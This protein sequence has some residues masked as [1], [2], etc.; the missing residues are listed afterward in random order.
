[1]IWSSERVS[2][3][4]EVKGKVAAR[5]AEERRRGNKRTID[6]IDKGA[7]S[8]AP[9]IANELFISTS[10]KHW[11]YDEATGDGSAM[12]VKGRDRRG[13]SGSSYLQTG[14]QWQ[15]V[16]TDRWCQWQFV[17]TDRGCQWQFVFTDRGCQWQLTVHIYRQVV[18]V[19]VHIHRDREGVND[20]SYS[21]RV[22]VTVRIHRDRV[23]VTVRIHRDR[24]G[25]SDS[26]YSHKQRGC[27]G[28][29]VFTE[30]GGVS[31]SVS[32]SGSSLLTCMC[33]ARNGSRVPALLSPCRFNN[34]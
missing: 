2:V 1:M 29:F 18:S 10:T 7:D 24:E 23:S 5:R 21:Q 4:E 16:F 11:H 6:F 9:A 25:V 27:Q 3:G 31:G 22:S 13:V 17:F 14:R 12:P 19:A 15:F 34:V 8:Q 33:F 20:S 26:S 28:Q 30:T 32:G